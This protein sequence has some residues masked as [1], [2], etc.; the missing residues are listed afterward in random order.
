V[1]AAVREWTAVEASPSFSS[2]PPTQESA[3]EAASPVQRSL[4]FTAL[5]LFPFL[6]V[7]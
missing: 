5:S 7:S 2:V 3:E 1:L 6:T 4:T